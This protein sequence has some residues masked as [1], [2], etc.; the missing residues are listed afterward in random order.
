MK[1]EIIAIGSEL[2]TPFR[3]DTNSLYLT[4]KLNELGIE[5]E[6]KTIVGDGLEHI[7][8]AVRAALW[9]ADL[10]I[11]TGGLGTTPTGR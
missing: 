7:R 1:A 4:R 8:D 2:L 11:L 6:F 10:L 5:V 3:Q 9:R